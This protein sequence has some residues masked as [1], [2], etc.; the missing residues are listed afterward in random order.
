VTPVRLARTVAL[1]VIIGIGLFNLIQAATH[2]TLSDAAAYWNAAQRLREGEPLYPVL[3]NVDASEVYRYA[4]WFAWLAVPFTFLSVQV[5]GALWSAILLAGSGLALVPLVRARAWVAVAFFA[6]ILV[7]ISAVGN[8]QP[9]LIA[10]L[11]WSAERRSGPLWI[12]VAAS[13]KVFP[14]LFALVYLGRGQWG[15]ALV[16]A[17]VAAVLWAPAL[18]YDLRGYATGAGQAAS[19]ISV[20]VLW[21]VVVGAAIG[22]TLRLARGP[23]AWVAAAASVVVALPRLFVYDVTY[24][25]VGVPPD[26]GRS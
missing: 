25:M 5:A 16:A 11:V 20:P 14:I 24:L 8:V 6:P 13:L 22:V 21:A 7:G 2:W 19:L 1:A 17:A 10:P 12:G 23:Y 4:P 15:R 18:L 26:D 9:L 3:S